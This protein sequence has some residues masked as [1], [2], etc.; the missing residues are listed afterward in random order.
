V[1]GM[2]GRVQ[3]RPERDVESMMS[4][5]TGHKAPGLFGDSPPKGMGNG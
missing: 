2:T 1:S 5:V 4:G 3:Y